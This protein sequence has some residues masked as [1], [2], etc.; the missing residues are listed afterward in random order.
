MHVKV[1]IIKHHDV[2]WGDKLII[3]GNQRRQQI[4]IV[5]SVKQEVCSG[6]FIIFLSHFWQV[7]E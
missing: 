5:D 6:S 1:V 4:N 2:S 3:S 7:A